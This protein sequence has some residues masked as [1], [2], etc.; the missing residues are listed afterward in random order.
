LDDNGTFFL[1]RCEG[2]FLGGKLRIKPTRFNLFADQ[3]SLAFEVEV[4]RIDAEELVKTMPGF[5]GE[6]RGLISGS[7][8]LTDRDGD[9]NYLGGGFLELMAAPKGYLSYPTDGLLTE[10]LDPKSSSY[11]KSRLVE[12]ALQDLNVAKL[13]LEFMED[14]LDGRF[15]KGEV[16]GES[17]INEKKIK[18]TYRP[19]L[20]GDIVA[21]LRKLEFG[22]FSFE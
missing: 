5:E 14:L 16:L 21:L 8:G 13:R 18:V 10:D 19:K 12:L 22:G 11:K 20:K 6:L 17:T 3:L 9:W 2:D 15:I 4:E 7:I 1:D